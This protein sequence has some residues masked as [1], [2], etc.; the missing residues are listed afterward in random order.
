MTDAVAASAAE[1]LEIRYH[2]GPQ[3]AVQGVTFTLA[4]GD[5]L[6]VTGAAGSGKTSLLRGMLGMVEHRGDLRILGAPAGDPAARRRVGYGP[7]GQGFAGGLRVG[8]AVGEALAARG[9]PR[10]ASGAALEAAGLQFVAG[11]RTRRLDAEGWRRLSLALAIAGN[12]DVIVLDDPW[13]LPDSLT[14]ISA[15]RARGAAVLVA[16]ERPAGLAPALGRR[17]A[18]IDG[19]VR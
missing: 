9:A 14:A 4:P 2:G 15:A 7:Q 8:E 13:L 17:L 3:P 5:G 11:W 18:L 12:P 6:L 16:A 19:R 1:D 10:A